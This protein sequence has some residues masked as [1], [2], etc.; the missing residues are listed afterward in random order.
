[1]KTISRLVA[2]VAG[3]GL[4]YSVIGADGAA[5]TNPKVRM[6]TSAGVIELEL[7]AKR[8][9]I[10]TENFLKYVDQGFYDG[11]VFHRVI[12]GFMIQGGGFLPGLKQKPTNATIK[13]EANNGLKNN[14]GT[15]AMARTNDPHSASAQFF[16]NTVN[17]P[18]LDH[19]EQS[20]QGWGYAVFGKVTSGM[21]IVKK[22]EGVATGNVGPHQNVPRQD[23]VIQKMER[24][25]A[26]KK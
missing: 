18:F 2:L 7:D 13:N 3:T 15:I 5:G 21:D 16:I 1:M 26:A 6:T 11:T 8:A 14:A 19:R 20:P 23:V 4:A 22:I 10:T 25:A 12:P 9:P 24:V 17:N